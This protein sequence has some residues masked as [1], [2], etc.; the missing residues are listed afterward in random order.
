M[1]IAAQ[2]HNFEALDLT[3]AVSNLDVALMTNSTLEALTLSGNNGAA[4]V[5][6]VAAGVNLLVSGENTAATTINVNRSDAAWQF[7]SLR[8]AGAV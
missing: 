3:A 2:F 6:N 5:S 7:G 1:G 8:S 4:T